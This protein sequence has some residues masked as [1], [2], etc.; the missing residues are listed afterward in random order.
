[1]KHVIQKDQKIEMKIHIN[2]DIEMNVIFQRFTLEQN[3]SLM[4]IKFLKFI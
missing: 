4:N 2:I 3:M 1:M